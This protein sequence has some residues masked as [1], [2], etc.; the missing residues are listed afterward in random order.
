MSTLSA[1]FPTPPTLWCIQ[2]D[3]QS[4]SKYKYRL[5][6]ESVD[7]SPEEK[8]LEMLVDQ[9]LTMSQKCAPIVQKAN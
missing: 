1:S 6:R 9:K 5:G 2:R 4:N 7:S 3:L 8:D